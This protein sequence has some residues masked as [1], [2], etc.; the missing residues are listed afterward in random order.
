MKQA[1]RLINR[2]KETQFIEKKIMTQKRSAVVLVFNQSGEM[3][4]QLRAKSD[5]K[6]PLHWDFSAAGGIDPGEEPI[7][8]A[9]R[10]LK[11]ELG[12]EAEL[13]FLGEVLYQDDF[14]QDYLYIY[15]AI[16]NGPFT[17]DSKEVERAEFFSP[18]HIELML[19]SQSFHPE[20]EAVWKKYK[21]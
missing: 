18:E 9:K 3:A 20:F 2:N 7:E 16:H 17:P 4:L 11:E 13:E 1:H 8:A 15:R 14:G 21:S 12:V 10:E 6:Y 5:D 19:L